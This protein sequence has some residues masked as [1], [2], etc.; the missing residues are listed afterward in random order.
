MDFTELFRVLAEAF[1]ER[2]GISPATVRELLEQR[3]RDS[4]TAVHT[5]LAIPHIVIEG[6]EKFDI[7]L[8]RSK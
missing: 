1:G 8:V 4:T 6:K 3:E 2:F 7:I 5:G